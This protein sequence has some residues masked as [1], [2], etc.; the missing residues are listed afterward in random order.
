M[1]GEKDKDNNDKVANDDEEVVESSGGI[2]CAAQLERI[3]HFINATLDKGDEADTDTGVQSDPQEQN[4]SAIVGAM[5]EDISD[6]YDSD[7]ADV[8]ESIIESEAEDLAKNC[9]NGM[10]C[11]NAK[12]QIEGI[13]Q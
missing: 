1:N 8:W 6:E 12:H 13:T 11:L 4:D 7:I 3:K 5:Q 9:W 2:D 10:R